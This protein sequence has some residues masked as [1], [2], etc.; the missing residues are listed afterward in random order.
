MNHASISATGGTATNV[1]RTESIQS[2]DINGGLQISSPIMPPTPPPQQ[3]PPSL[4]GYTQQHPSNPLTNNNC[5]PLEDHYDV[6]AV[7][8]SYVSV[9]PSQISLVSNGSHYSSESTVSSTRSASPQMTRTTVPPNQGYYHQPPPTNGTHPLPP[10][11]QPLYQSPVHNYN[12]LPFVNRSDM[13]PSA[14][15]YIPATLPRPRKDTNP[16]PTAPKPIK[17]Q[18][19]LYNPHTQ[20]YPHQTQ[21]YRQQASQDSNSP[22]H[23]QQP[24]SRLTKQCSLPEK[25]P[26]S[27]EDSMSSFALALKQKKLRKTVRVSDRSTPRV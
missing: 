3:E 18:T 4:A 17:S 19:Q 9:S 25:D 21:Q 24:S 27:D 26:S 15:K 20:Q 11:T 2:F 12:D 7:P 8:S 10:S 22:Q 13:T 5:P 1:S 16:K 14:M 23:Y 6:P